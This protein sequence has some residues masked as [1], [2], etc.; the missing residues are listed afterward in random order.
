MQYIETRT[1]TGDAMLFPALKRQSGRYSHGPSRW[2]GL[3]KTKLGFQR[4]KS[5][6]SFRHTFIDKLRVIQAPD[7]IIKGLAGHS[8]DSM[9]HSVYGSKSPVPLLPIVEQI[10]WRSELVDVRPFYSADSELTR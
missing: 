1:A 9:T 3:F 8:G 2:F 4:D 6:H 7:Y 10:D 5:F